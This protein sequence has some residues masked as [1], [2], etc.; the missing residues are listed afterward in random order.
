MDLIREIKVSFD[1]LSICYWS[2]KGVFGNIEWVFEGCSIWEIKVGYELG[3]VV[4]SFCISF[5]SFYCLL[6]I[7]LFFFGFRS[8][9]GI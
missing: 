3:S 6:L 7:C 1:M 5:F 8:G 9:Y 2:K 4:E